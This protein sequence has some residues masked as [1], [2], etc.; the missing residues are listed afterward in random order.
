MKWDLEH[1]DITETRRTGYPYD[2]RQ[3]WHEDEMDEYDEYTVEQEIAHDLS[4]ADEEIRYAL[5]TLY[6]R[7][8]QKK[9]DILKTKRALP[10][11]CKTITG[12]LDSYVEEICCVL[13]ALDD[14]EDALM[15]WNDD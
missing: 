8:V 7:L 11:I 10:T 15:M 12:R 9:T 6:D 2:W 5:R 14:F 1:P 3:N 4:P 13:D